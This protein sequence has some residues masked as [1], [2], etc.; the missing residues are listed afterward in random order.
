M[1]FRQEVKRYITTL[2]REQGC[3]R[4]CEN[5]PGCLDFHHTDPT[6]KEFTIAEFLRRHQPRFSELLG[7]IAKCQILCRN[8]HAKEHYNQ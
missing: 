2:K 5:H 3:S 6:G 7:E 8:C 4:C 1:T